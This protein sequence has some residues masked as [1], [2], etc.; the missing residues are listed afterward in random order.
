MTWWLVIIKFSPFFPSW[1]LLLLI[2]AEEDT[3]LCVTL[4]GLLPVDPSQWNSACQ[5]QCL[6]LLT[7]PKWSVKIAMATTK[8]LNSAKGLVDVNCPALYQHNIYLTLCLSYSYLNIYQQ[9]WQ[10][11]HD[12]RRSQ[13][14]KVLSV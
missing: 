6:D 11:R 10:G 3:P 7:H 1:G 8:Y 5:W 14:R 12:K 2:L 9:I 4:A 13:I